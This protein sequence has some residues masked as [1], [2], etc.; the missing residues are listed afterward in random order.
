MSAAPTAHT[1]TVTGLNPAT[2]VPTLEHFFSFCGKISA[3]AA[4]GG[5]AKVS[6]VK[7][8]AAK[9]ALMLSGG[10]LESHVIT[11]KSDEL[12]AHVPPTTSA[13]AVAEKEEK[14]E[15]HEVEQESKPRAA[16]AAEYLAHGYQL[17]DQAIQAAIHADNTY[18]ISSKFLSF[19]NPLAE[20]VQK[21]AA[22]H[23]ETAQTKFAEADEKQGLSL[24]AS[25]AQQIG[26][27]YYNNALASPLGSKVLA[28]YT[29][30]QKQVLDVH[31][32][33]LRI[34]NAKA[35]ASAST[36]TPAPAASATDA[37][38]SEKAP[39]VASA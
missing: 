16:I 5:E 17:S 28:F 24:R 9:T 26:K 18:G 11:V 13:P 35:A 4:E 10:T 34:K 31:E 7:E 37:S 27:V 22:P 30:A 3:V 6:F 21:A 1:V 8:S 19:F 25:A 36:E 38:I 15:H 12:E 23:I 39:A 14:S 29:Q 32:E 20:K 2:T 33:A